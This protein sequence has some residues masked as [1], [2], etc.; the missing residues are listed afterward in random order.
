MFTSTKKGIRQQA[1]R[2]IALPGSA[3]LALLIGVA[4]YVIDRDWASALFLLPVAA[5]QPDTSAL[6]GPLGQVLP[7]FLH[8]YAFSL[9]LILALGHSRNA[10]RNGALTWFAIASCLEFLQAT[11]FHDLLSAPATPAAAAVATSVQSYVLNGQF[12]PGDV[13]A[14]GLGCA[15]AFA[16]SSVLEVTR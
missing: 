6:F 4:V 15:A 10:R 2:K 13:V 1:I 14:S 7:S 11:Y 3:V 16:I 8:A 5:F 9:L 12:D